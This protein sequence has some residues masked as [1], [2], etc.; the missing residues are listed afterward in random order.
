MTD[1]TSTIDITSGVGAGSTIDA[2]S[3]IGAGPA[4]PG[5]VHPVLDN[6]AWHALTTVHAHLAEGSGPV[7]RYQPDVAGFVAIESSTPQAWQALAELVGPGQE[8]M[9][10]GR[11]AKQPPPGWERLGGGYGFQMV[12]AGFNDVPVADVEISILGPAHVPE[13]LDLIEL[14]KPGPFRPR[15]I[16]LGEYSGI[17]ADGVLV[18]MAGERLQTPDFTEVSAVCTH[19]SVRGLG[20]ASTLTRHV[21]NGI[22]A[23]GQTPILH[24]A[25]TNTNAKAVYER[26]GFAVRTRLEF[27]GLTTPHSTDQSN[28]Q[29][30]DQSSTAANA[31][32]KSS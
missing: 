21:A 5:E 9:L 13:I 14:T 2:T 25:E 24:V 31:A 17:F 18:A 3:T 10:S 23:R 16:E 8:V 26:L 11:E 30:N 22:L 15:T 12:L 4:F 28:V 1:T 7:R 20:Y 32:R 19:P 27:V 6:L 29:S